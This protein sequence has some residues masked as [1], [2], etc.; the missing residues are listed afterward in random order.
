MSKYYLRVG[1][2]F[3]KLPINLLIGNSRDALT[4]TIAHRNLLAQFIYVFVLVRY[5]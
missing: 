5:I 2:K 3:D 1:L 4:S